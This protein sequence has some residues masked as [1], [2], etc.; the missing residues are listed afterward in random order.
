MSNRNHKRHRLVRK[1]GHWA[2]VFVSD[3]RPP[4]QQPHA[5]W[6][7]AANQIVDKAFLYVDRAAVAMVFLA[8]SLP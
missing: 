8:R 3:E 5:D 2:S 7:A 4:V 1:N 6:R